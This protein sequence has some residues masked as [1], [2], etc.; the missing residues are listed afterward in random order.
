MKNVLVVA[1]EEFEFAGILRRSRTVE[2]ADWGTRFS[3]VVE[4]NGMRLLLAA[5]GPG[6]KLAGIAADAVYSRE[7]VDA[8]VS[9][10]LCGGLEPQ[11]CVGDIFVATEVNGTTAQRPFTSLPHRSGKVLSVDR[12]AVSP[13]EKARLHETGAAVV[14]M[15]AQALAERAKCWQVPFYCV[16]SVSD[17]A[18]EGFLLDLNDVRDK[19]G[20]FRRGLIVLKTV[21]RPFTLVPEMLRLKRNSERAAD[22]LGE[23]VANCCF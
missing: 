11:L 1:A 13:V 4:L 3:R 23:F 8:V 14:E 22:T 7:T 2:K 15:E 5:H 6:P 12:V 10:G 21:F 9:T 20:R 17:G 18:A 16:R 19:E